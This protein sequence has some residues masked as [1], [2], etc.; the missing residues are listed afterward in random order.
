MRTLILLL[1]LL[2]T[3]APSLAQPLQ[4]SYPPLSGDLFL[5]SDL[6]LAG[7][8]ARSSE[9]LHPLAPDAGLTLAA[10][11]H[12]A[13]MAALGYLSHTSPVAE[14]A[15]VQHRLA[16]AGSPL[17]TVGENLANVQGRPDLAQATIQGWLES[18]GH[19]ANLLSAKF[20]HVGYGAAVDA[21]GATLIAQVLA[22]KPSTLQRSAVEPRLLTAR[23]I[24]VT[25][26]ASEAARGLVSVA[27][28][29]DHTFDLAAGVQ[30]VEIA[31]LAELSGPVQIRAGLAL[32]AGAN[33]V[34]QDAGWLDTSS[35]AWSPD[36]SSVRQGL[37]I[38]AVVLEQRHQG[39]A[40]VTLAYD[41][42]PGQQLA[43][44]LGGAQQRD[45]VAGAGLVSVV[46]PDDGLAAPL[47]I[48]LLSGGS[49]EIFHSF[50]LANEGGVPTLRPQR[51]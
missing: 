15:T 40:A 43:V 45:A 31:T 5:E 44:F 19:R 23:R 46:L 49:V 10:R 26:R 35:G 20:T 9:G 33:F 18:P 32:G 28:A 11:H 8:L 42:P 48:G 13:E 47:Q 41:L 16:L 24:V 21:N 17:V 34:L 2:A 12:A 30:Q 22:Y 14:H 25:L 50:I 1:T 3:A 51:P 6:L 4:P 39:G 38:E 27:G 37:T 29:G 36:P 7:N